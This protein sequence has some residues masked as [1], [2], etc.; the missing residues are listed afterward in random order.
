MESKAPNIK[1]PQ[2][3]LWQKIE[4]IV[5]AISELCDTLPRGEARSPILEQ[6][7]ALLVEH[8]A[9]PVSLPALKKICEAVAKLLEQLGADL[10]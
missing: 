10:S 7:E 1:H 2:P 4:R 9:E 5:T 6:L 8:H 3:D